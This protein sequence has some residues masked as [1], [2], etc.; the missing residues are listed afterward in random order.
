MSGPGEEAGGTGAATDPR[1]S[2]PK[3]RGRTYAIPFEKVWTRALHLAGGGIP[4]W[5]VLRA[6]DRPG[7][8]LAVS[9]SAL[10]RHPSDVRITVGL[11]ANGQ[12]RVDLR[13][14]TRDGKGGL[15]RNVRCIDTFL[16]HLDLQLEARQGL[17]LDDA[18][19]SHWRD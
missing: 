15:R 11:D 10:R 8:I 1:S 6:D 12:T 2:D 16:R 14:R 18:N 4:R 9:K 19:P 17:I 13:A 3:L 5:H 7:V